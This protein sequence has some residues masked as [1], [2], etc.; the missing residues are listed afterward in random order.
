MRHFTPYLF[1]PEYDST[2]S[3]E[4]IVVKIVFKFADSPYVM[5]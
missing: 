1:F 2:S 4:V 5:C 3:L